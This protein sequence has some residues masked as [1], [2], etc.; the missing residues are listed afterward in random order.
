[1]GTLALLT[2]PGNQDSRTHSDKTTCFTLTPQ[3]FIFPPAEGSLWHPILRQ[4]LGRKFE[5]KN[6]YPLI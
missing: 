6:K 4:R 1:M 3:N 2:L 5:I